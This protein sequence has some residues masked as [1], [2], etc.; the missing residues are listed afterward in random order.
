MDKIA[1]R[2]SMGLTAQN[3]FASLQDM[4]DGGGMGQSGQAF[5]GGPFSGLL[6]GLGMKPAGYEERLAA[7]RPMARPVPS[8][9]PVSRPQPMPAPQPIPSNTLPPEGMPTALPSVYEMWKM[10]QARRNGQGPQFWQR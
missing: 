4:F 3:R 7:A 8:V 6:N 10:D 9:Q 1:V 5:E 2:N